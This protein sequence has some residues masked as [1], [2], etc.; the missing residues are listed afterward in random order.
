V[1]ECLDRSGDAAAACGSARAD[2]YTDDVLEEA[3]R[4]LPQTVDLLDT[5]SYFC[6][7]EVCPAIVGNVRVYMD[8]G[9]VTGTYMRTVAPLLE[10]DLLRLTGW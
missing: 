5:S 8:S 3:A 9:H 2:V 1:P 6:T 7:D 10:P 4:T